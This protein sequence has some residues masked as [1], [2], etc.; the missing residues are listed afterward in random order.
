MNEIARLMDSLS[1]SEGLNDTW[2]DGVRIYRSTIGTPRSPLIYGQGVIIVGQGS[3][4]VYVG[5]K[6]YEYDSDHYLVLSVPL[7]AE[8]EASA[9]PESPFLAMMV[10]IDLGQINSIL[11]I[12]DEYMDIS[13]L[14]Q[15]GDAQGLSVARADSELKDTVLKLLKILQ[16]PMETD[17]LG[18]LMIRDLTFRLL[19]GENACSL[20]G[21]AMKNTNLSRIDKAL[22][23][24]HSNYREPMDVENLAGLVNMS[25]SAFHRAFKDVTSSSP[26]QYIKKVRLNKAKDLLEER[27]LRVGEAASRV[28]Y[29]S[30]TH[31]SREFKRY[32][33][34][35][36]VEFSHPQR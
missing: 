25:V 11:S 29:E 26:I 19:N 18:G 31:F 21:L 36:P 24:I 2:L 15:A 16:S 8:C 17:I 28:G 4:R 22:K 13:T 1:P 3:K 12:M 30:P 34:T 5:D 35:S 9:T 10:D 27:G 20:Y 33:G 7:P 14:S 23:K 32:F 6:T